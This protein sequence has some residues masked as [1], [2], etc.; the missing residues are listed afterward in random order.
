MNP[1]FQAI[2]FGAIL[3]L[4]LGWVLHVGRDVLVPLAFGV[5]VAY[6]I[7]GLTQLLLRVP[8]LGRRMPVQLRNAASVLVISSGLVGMVYLLLASSDGITAYAPKYQRSLL[9]GIQRVAVLL[10]IES[11][12]T[13]TTLRNDLL[14]Q[15]NLQRLLGSVVAS[16]SSMVAT[17]AVVILY[18]AFL[19]MEQRYFE[20]KLVQASGDPRNAARIREVTGA[21]NRRVGA[22]LSVKTA[23]NVL[24]GGVCW[25]IMA[26]LGV[27]FAGL[28]AVLIGLLNYIPYAGSFFGV[29]IPVAVALG[30]FGEPGAVLGLLMGL[31]AAQVVIGNFLDPYLMGSSLNLSPFA[32]LV[33]LAVWSQ[34]WGV[35]GAVL[36][37]PITSVMVIVFSE[38]GGTRPIAI[39]LSKNGHP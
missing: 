36:A 13:W 18:A 5:L 11:E 14:G 34:L 1:R 33:A 22:Y 39:L 27:Q 26:L 8:G 3:A 12:P 37:V 28:L 29:V 20:E 9:A 30:Q 15:I 24:L 19:M 38:F 2:V 10:R 35:A 31:T 16:V 6:V 4:I 7:F 23:I 17:V 21:I 32:I 25:V